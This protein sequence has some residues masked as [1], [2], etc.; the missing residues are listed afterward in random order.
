VHWDPDSPG[1]M[2]PLEHA[3]VSWLPRRRWFAGKG[4]DPHRARIVAAA[5]LTP[6]G[7]ARGA[8][9]VVE[10][11]YVDGT[12]ER[13]Q[14][15]LG[16]RNVQESDIGSAAI[17]TAV[18]GVV[19][20]AT[21]DAALMASLLAM[22]GG[23]RTV[24]GFGFRPEPGSWIAGSD[25]IPGRLLDVE[26][27]NSSIVFEDRAILKLFRRLPPGVNPEL[28]LHRVIGGAHVPRL[29]G[30]VE[31]VVDGQPVT[32]GVLHEFAAGAEDGWRLATSVV[33]DL[34]SGKDDGTTF[35]ADVERLGAAVAEVHIELADR[36]GTS[37]MDA[38]E[39]ADAMC[40]RLADAVGTAP[41][42]ARHV[43]RIRAVYRAPVAGN[44]KH[45]VQ[46]VHGDL[47]L[48]QVL[49]AEQ[50]WLLIDFEGEPDGGDRG[51]AHSPLRDVA[52]MLRS[53]DYAAARAGDAWSRYQLER[54]LS[55]VR[56]AFQ[57]GYAR[58]SGIDLDRNRAVLNAYELDKA[59]Y[60][61]AYET[62]NRPDWAE[63]PLRAV[64]GILGG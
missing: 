21:V 53:F 33:R 19:Y 12:T 23:G 56:G 11:S 32:L 44:D 1:R 3:L 37:T 57:A 18:D 64:L 54:W 35:V 10:V 9:A 61:V 4:R 26:Q 15:P 43:D 5:E 38:V 24:D 50:G 31:G 42:L 6:H 16:L 41:A 47:H 45:V 52:G 2:S 22:I 30:A 58:A 49:R 63:I 62:R 39:L 36:L 17:M 60:E 55:Q 20:D 13:Y 29:L 46:R 59:V 40:A 7:G 51:V 14:V 25:P 27:S 28:E 48:G 8:L 34:L